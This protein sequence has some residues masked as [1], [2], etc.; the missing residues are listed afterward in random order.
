MLD[1][2]VSEMAPRKQDVEKLERDYELFLEALEEDEDMKQLLEGVEGL[3]LEEQQDHEM[4][5]AD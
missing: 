5:E 4:M 3:G 1:K 2:E